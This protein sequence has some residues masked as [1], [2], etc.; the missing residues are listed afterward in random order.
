VK[1][2]GAI[3]VVKYWRAEKIAAAAKEK[4]I[5]DETKAVKE[6]DTL[7]RTAVAQRMVADV[8]LGALLS[9]GIDSSLVVALMQVQSAQPVRTFSIGFAEERYNEAPYAKAVA[10][11]LQTEHHEFYVAPADALLSLMLCPIISTSRSPTRRKYPRCSCLAW[12]AS[13]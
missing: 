12:R 5:A 4:S 10:R 3:E 2:G 6:L 8:P 9:G 7:L 1:Q 13:M 11:H